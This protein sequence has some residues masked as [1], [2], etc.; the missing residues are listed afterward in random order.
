MKKAELSERA[1]LSSGYLTQLENPR[2]GASIKQP[3]LEILQRLADVLAVPVGW[4][5]FGTDPE[6]NW[7]EQSPVALTDD[8]PSEGGAPTAAE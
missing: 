2:A 7:P 5:A 8:E 4:L 1:G 3:S 6:P